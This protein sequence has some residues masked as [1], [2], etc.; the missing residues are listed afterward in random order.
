[1]EEDKLRHKDR[2]IQEMEME[3]EQLRKQFD[4]QMGHKNI[5]YDN[6]KRNFEESAYE[7]EN[8]RRT[9]SAKQE[10][11]LHLSH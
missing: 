7:C 8:L 1:M 9:L 11:I 2:V 5:D 10:E 4:D 6:L 3:R